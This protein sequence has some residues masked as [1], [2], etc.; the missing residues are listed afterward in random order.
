MYTV[1]IITASDKGARGEREDKSAEVIRA[2][3]VEAGYHVAAYEIVPDEMSALT[4][5]MMKFADELGVNLILTTGGTGF[6]KRDVTPEA[7]LKVIE[8]EARGIPEAMRQL[9]LNITPK[10]M[11]SRAVAG[12]RGNTLIVNLPGSPKAVRE[13]L[14]FIIGPIEHG[15]EILMGDAAECAEPMKQK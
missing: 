1:G 15:L 9:S 5:C 8:R 14:G 11:L 6:S 10:A 3:V 13:H 4:D 2:M 12:I 7:T